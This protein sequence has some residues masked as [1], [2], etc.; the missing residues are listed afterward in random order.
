M[1]RTILSFYNRIRHI[2]LF[3]G[4]I[5]PV[6][7]FLVENGS[8]VV[9]SE[10][11]SVH[12]RYIS[13]DQTTLLLQTEVIFLFLGSFFNKKDPSFSTLFPVQS[14]IHYFSVSFATGTR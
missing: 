7:P 5:C 14:D 1:C 13:N 11:Y 2:C 10:S 8:Y 4:Q 12:L 3:H 6:W 9:T